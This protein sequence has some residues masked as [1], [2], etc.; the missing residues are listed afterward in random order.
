ML[1]QLRLTTHLSVSVL[2]YCL[3]VQVLEPIDEAVKGLRL[4]VQR[5][6]ASVHS[7]LGSAPS[8]LLIQPTKPL[9]A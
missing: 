5:I 8:P 7:Y 1:L 9:R 3:P 6:S 2:W 4:D